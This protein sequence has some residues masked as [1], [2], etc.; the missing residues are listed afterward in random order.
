LQAVM[1]TPRLIDLRNV[2]KLADM[3]TRPFQYVSVGRP[4]ITPPTQ[5]NLRRVAT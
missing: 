4:D 2:Y 1:K 3:E 5:N